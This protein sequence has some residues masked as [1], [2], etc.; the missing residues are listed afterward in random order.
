MSNRLSTGRVQHVSGD[1]AERAVTKAV[2]ESKAP[3]NEVAATIA[4]W[5][6]TPWGHGLTFARLAQGSEV[7]REDLADAI[8]HQIGESREHDRDMWALS[9]WMESR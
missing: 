1:E 2:E 6:Q 9:T 4:S 8:G 3:S 5:Y 7:L